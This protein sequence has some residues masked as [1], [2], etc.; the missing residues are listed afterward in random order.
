MLD[1]H[2]MVEFRLILRDKAAGLPP[3]DKI[4]NALP[5]RLERGKVDD[6]ARTGRRDELNEF[7][8]RLH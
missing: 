2:V 8:V 6:F 7:L 1:F 4:P 3:F 5:R